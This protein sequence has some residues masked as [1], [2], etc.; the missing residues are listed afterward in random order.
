[1][2]FLPIIFF[3]IFITNSFAQQF[4][5][6]CVKNA[7]LENGKELKIHDKIP[8]TGQVIIKTD[9][10]IFMVNSAAWACRLLKEESYDLDSVYVTNK[11]RQY[12]R[13]SAKTIIDSVFPDGIKAEFKLG[14]GSGF[15]EKSLDK[16]YIFSNIEVLNREPNTIKIK[17]DDT[18]TLRWRDPRYKGGRYFL[19][20]KNMFDEIVDYTIA[21]TA[22]YFVDFNNV[23]EECD[24]V[25]VYS[26]DGRASQTIF[27]ERI[28]K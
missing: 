15:N 21:N 26:E 8:L 16:Y 23:A 12:V 25:T 27:I 5:V 14:C 4:E 28:K 10:H 6:T 17:A 7:F 18:L 9:G 11:K 13:D 1:M 19:V 22:S 3:V 20:F 24:I 2:K